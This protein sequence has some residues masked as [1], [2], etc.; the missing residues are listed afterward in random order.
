[1]KCGVYRIKCLANGY[2]YVGS[3]CDME[4]RL[5]THLRSLQRGCHHNVFLQRV[6]NKYGRESF[7]V[8]L[9]ETSSIEDARELEQKYLDLYSD[10]K[11]CMNIGRAASGGDNLTKHPNR[12]KIIKRRTESVRRRIDSMTPE[13]KISAYSKPGKQNGMYGRTHTEET[14][15][16]LSDIN[17]GNSYALGAT[18]SEETKQLLRDSIKQRQKDGT[19]VNSF[20]GKTH[21]S[22]QKKKWSKFFKA[23]AEAGFLPPNTL[24]IRVGKKVYRSAAQAAKHIG[25]QTATILNRARNPN[26]PDYHILD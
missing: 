24:K 18:R 20:K 15:K 17:K 13:E 10:L 23:R 7:N 26:F 4:K 6:F 11:R 3:S 25:C 8:R 19:Y 21:S 9:K 1:M 22:A 5:R 16:F 12:K 2:F 14:R